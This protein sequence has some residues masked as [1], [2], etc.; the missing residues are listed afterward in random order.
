[1]L[2]IIITKSVNN[3]LGKQ[4]LKSERSP[5]HCLIK[6]AK[7]GTAVKTQSQKSHNERKEA[8]TPSFLV[9]TYYVPGTVLRAEETM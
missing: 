5:G 1:M 7:A 4:S 2:V 8:S 3:Y 9:C 6:G